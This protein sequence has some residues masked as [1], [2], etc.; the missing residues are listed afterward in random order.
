MLRR[1][2]YDTQGGAKIFAEGVRAIGL[3]AEWFHSRWVF[4]VEISARYTREI[5][6]SEAAAQHIYEFRFMNSDCSADRSHRRT[7]IG[8]RGGWVIGLL[9]NPH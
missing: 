5:G 2:V 3:T 8:F 9:E 1:P 6:S 7:L 4:Y